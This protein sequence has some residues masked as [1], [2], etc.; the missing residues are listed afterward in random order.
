MIAV[1]VDDPLLE[2]QDPE[3]TPN[4]FQGGFNHSQFIIFFFLS[5]ND[6]F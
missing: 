1:K 5:I 4:L 6:F 3:V 2:D